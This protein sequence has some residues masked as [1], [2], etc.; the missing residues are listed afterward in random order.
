MSSNKQK[1]TIV[2]LSGGLDSSWTAKTLKDQGHKLLGVFLRLGVD[3]EEGEARARQV[4]KFLDINF[5]PLNLAG[6]FQ[7]EIKNYFLDSYAQGRT[8][9]P[10][11]KC[12]KFIKFDSLLE[13]ADKLGYDYVAT[14][15]YALLEKEN[16]KIYLKR[17]EDKTK[18]QSYFLYKLGPAQLKR[19]FFPLGN[20]LKTEVE[21]QARKS[22]IPYL[23]GE[24]QDICFIPGDHNDYLRKNLEFQRGAIKSLSGEVLGEHQGLPFY[25]IGQR[26]GVEIGAIGPLYVVKLDYKNNTL[27][28]TDDS[29]HPSLLSDEFEVEEVNWIIPEPKEKLD[30]EVVIRYGGK[31]VSA[32]VFPRGK[33]CRVKLK[34]KVRALTSGQSA[35]FYQGDY[36]LGGGVIK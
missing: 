15:H 2:A 4:C 30:S 13:L 11:V 3:D 26:R 36:V 33:I 28:V 35:V 17:G 22:K 1:K 29:N 9:N 7:E 27:Y 23:K 21:A 14:G 20:Y 5:Y 16:G 6:K 34:N 10:C 8:P 25:T 32:Q 19:L 31:P 12:N 18:D 24:S